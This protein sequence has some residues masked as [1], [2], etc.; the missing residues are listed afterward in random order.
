MNV[1]NVLTSGPVDLHHA[2]GSAK[3]SLL[4]SNSQRTPYEADTV[5]A[6]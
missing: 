4:D 2:L 6:S 3:H 5:A 1:R